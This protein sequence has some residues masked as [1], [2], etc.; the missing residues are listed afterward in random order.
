MRKGL[1][2]YRDHLAGDLIEDANG[3]TFRYRP[4]Y[5][6]NDSLPS[7][8]LTLPKRKEPYVSKHLFA[9]F[10]G[11]LA[12]GIPKAIQCKYLRIDEDDDF[13]RLLATSKYDC[14]GAVY[15]IAAK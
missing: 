14:A 3:Y 13:G 2:Y 4:E 7:V 10:F 5:L 1:V 6:T 12:E 9:F 8:S 15:V 11:L